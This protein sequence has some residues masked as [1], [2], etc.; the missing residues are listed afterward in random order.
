MKICLGV[1]R[2]LIVIV[3][4]AALVAG[5]SGGGGSSTPSSTGSSATSATPSPSPVTASPDPSTEPPWGLDA[6]TLPG[7]T[8]AVRAV[9]EAL[10]EDIA[11]PVKYEAVLE[12]FDPVILRTDDGRGTIVAFPW[13]RV[14]AFPGKPGSLAF[15]RTV[16]RDPSAQVEG[17]SL[18]A[19][20]P[21]VWIAWT[22]GPQS[23]AAWGDPGSLWV[24]LVTA[25][26]EPA[27]ATIA[28]LFADAASR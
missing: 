12:R 2:G 21:I 11:G 25:D 24:F 9:L 20:A 28:Q 19:R 26:S 13:S 27:R 7:D 18:D 4:V 14:R 8:Q 1:A 16:T 15:L 22:S 6:V 3:S 5:C 23:F 10:P 17:R